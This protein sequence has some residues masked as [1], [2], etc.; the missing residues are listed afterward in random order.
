MRLCFQ[1]ERGDVLYNIGQVAIHG[2]IKDESDLLM[3]GNG[4][5][6]VG[7][8]LLDLWS[9]K[10]IYSVDGIWMESKKCI[11]I[12]KNELLTVHRI[13]L[14][15]IQPTCRHDILSGKDARFW[16]LNSFEDDSVADTQMSSNFGF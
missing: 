14:V 13:Y 12:L 11:C 9:A 7:Q 3:V 16:R 8:T 6:E 15:P 5:K 1:I 2:Y 4:W 10:G